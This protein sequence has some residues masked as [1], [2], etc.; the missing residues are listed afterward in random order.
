VPG[1]VDAIFKSRN[2]QGPNL[3]TVRRARQQRWRDAH[4]PLDD[5]LEDWEEMIDVN[6]KGVLYGI[7]A[8]LPV[9]R[10]QTFG[11]F[12]NIASVAGLKLAEHGGLF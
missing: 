8:A 10:R 11:H 5:L 9:S 7:A 1:W 3:S 2:L 4:F 6:I 12:V